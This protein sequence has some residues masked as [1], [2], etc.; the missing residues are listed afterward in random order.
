[1]K[2]LSTKQG[3]RERRAGAKGKKVLVSTSFESQPIEREGRG[4]I[5]GRG[6]KIYKMP[7]E[8]LYQRTQ[9]VPR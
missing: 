4:I 2:E 3:G 6:K 7:S 5:K 8:G 9:R 1:L